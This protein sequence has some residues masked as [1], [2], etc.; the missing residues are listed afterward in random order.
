MIIFMYGAVSGLAY[1]FVSGSFRNDHD[2]VKAM[3]R[4]IETLA[5]Y[6]V[7]VFFIAQFVALFNWTNVGIVTAVEGADLLWQL[8][9][10]PIPLMI[11][12][13]LLAAF[14]DLVLGSATAKW[15]VMAPIFVPM[16]MLLGYSPELAQ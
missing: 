11:A 15:A 6:V 8:G 7:L 3:T 1:G 2:V 13:V 4:A 9:L 10:G 5:G 12:F 14:I 16:F